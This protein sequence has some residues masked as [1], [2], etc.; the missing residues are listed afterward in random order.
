[1]DK[2][3]ELKI[4]EEVLDEYHI[5]KGYMKSD[6]IGTYQTFL[7]HTDY[8]IVKLY[9]K[10][11]E[12]FDHASEIIDEFKKENGDLLTYRKVAR[13]EVGPMLDELYEQVAEEEARRVAEEQ[14]LANF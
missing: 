8:K 11:L 12:D 4:P 1:M 7:M 5:Y 2:E 6:F 9:E 3:Y 14:A 13:E 10:V